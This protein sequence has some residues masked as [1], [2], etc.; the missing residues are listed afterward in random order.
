MTSTAVRYSHLTPNPNSE[1]RQLFVKG[2]RIRA[3]VLYGWYACDDPMTAEE[4]AQ[5]FG[6]PLAAVKEAVAYCESNPPE[7]LEDYAR[8]EAV[9]EATG[10]NDPA[11]KHHPSPRL[12][13]AQERA[14]LMDAECRDDA[15]DVRILFPSV[16]GGE[17]TSR[18][19]MQETP[20]D[21]LITNVSMLN[22]ILAREVDS[23]IIERTRDWLMTHNDAYFFLVLDELHLQRGSAGTETSYLLRLL[24]ERPTAASLALVSIMPSRMPRAAKMNAMT[25]P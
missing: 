9:M 13:T 25:P 12:L 24:F 3:R 16:D 6:L 1:Y 2:T 15:E 11:Y 22:A 19:D 14:R 23:P 21:L 20:P 4:I 5:E 18:W 7:L 8:E 10:M 17:L